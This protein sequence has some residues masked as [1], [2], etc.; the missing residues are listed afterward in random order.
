MVEGEA[1]DG[2]VHLALS[3]DALLAE[4]EVDLYRASGP[5]GQKRNKIS[6]AVRL[7]HRPTGLMGN[8]VEDRSQHVNRAR[9]L[10]R[11]RHTLALKARG[12]ID[13]PSYEPSELLQ[14]YIQKK[15]G[16]RVNSKNDDFARVACE[17]LDVLAACDLRVSDAAGNIGLSTANLVKFLFSDPNLWGQVNAM[18]TA[19]GLKPLRS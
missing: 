16:L 10:R 15:G 6:S 18:R 8:A 2:Q 19:A 13:L 12:E 1:K 4:C 5:G 7:R 11:L 14:R 9:A 17:L 3:D